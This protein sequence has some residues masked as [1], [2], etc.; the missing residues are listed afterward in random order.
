MV[1]LR[2][3]SHELSTASRSERWSWRIVPSSCPGYRSASS[4][5]I[6]QH[7]HTVVTLLVESAVA[8]IVEDVIGPLA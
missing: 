1:E 4:L 6:L 5:L 7:E 2:A 8:D 3:P